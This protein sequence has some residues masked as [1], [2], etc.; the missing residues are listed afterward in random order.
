MTRSIVD[1][2]T[3]EYRESA[4]LECPK[5][6]IPSHN[7]T[8]DKLGQ[9]TGGSMCGLCGARVSTKIR[10]PTEDCPDKHPTQPGLTRWND[11]ISING[12]VPF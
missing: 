5:L 7:I 4:C 9:K 6:I 10:L 1:D 12:S 3:L 11:P 8:K 2:K